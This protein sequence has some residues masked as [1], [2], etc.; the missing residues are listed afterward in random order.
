MKIHTLNSRT[1]V[2]LDIL[3]K[4][5]GFNFEYLGNEIRSQYGFM[6]N[7]LEKNGIN[8]FDLRS[9]LTPQ[10]KKRYLLNI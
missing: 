6:I 5:F 9:T 8:Y 4:D 3:N 2:L 10:Q 7:E 1:Y